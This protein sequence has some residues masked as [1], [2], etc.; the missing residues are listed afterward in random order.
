M[1]NM[2]PAGD[3][4]GPAPEEDVYFS[5]L[6]PHLRGLANQLWVLMGLRKFGL[7]LGYTY[8][9]AYQEALRD[10][11]LLFFSYPSRRRPS[12]PGLLYRK[13]KLF[14]LYRFFRL[15]YRNVYD[16][17]GLNQYLASEKRLTNQQANGFDSM[18]LYLSD[19]FLEKNN[20]SSYHELQHYVKKLV[21]K[22]KK[23]RPLLLELDVAYPLSRWS[24][25]TGSASCSYYDKG[26]RAA[27]FQQRKRCPQKSRF[28]QG[29]LKTLVHIRLGDRAPL[30]T[31]RGTWLFPERG[32]PLSR[33]EETRDE[34]EFQQLTVADFYKFMRRLTSNFEH[35][36]FATQF[37]SDGFKRALTYLRMRNVTG[38][39]LSPREVS[40]ICKR[41]RRLQREFRI[42]KNV[43]NS[44]CFIGEGIPRLFG[45]IHALMEADLVVTGF[46]LQKGLLYGLVRVY[47]TPTNMP[48]VIFLHKPGMGGMI[49]SM[50]EPE[51]ADKIIGIDIASPDF[52]G[53]TARLSELL[54]AKRGFP[55]PPN[56]RPCSACV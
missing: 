39:Y 42:L 3:K 34:S 20:I 53:L 40:L 26:L 4:S 5:V 7:Q 19:A 52:S 37:Y 25:L 32:W 6:C 28:P 16:F 55:P 22:K 49:P 36:T 31:P 30:P 45:L 24:E 9:H 43:P 38:G 23:S 8:L 46:P 18:R 2:T 48:I 21:S 50:I 51:R 33:I 29:A 41:K 47:T 14:L 10:S 17:L 54:A 15:Y 35:D 56:P 44:R 11:S 1:R 12:S 13:V 27:Y